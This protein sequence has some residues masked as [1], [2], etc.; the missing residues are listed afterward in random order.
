MPISISICPAWSARHDA[1]R[2]D[3]RGDDHKKSRS[4]PERAGDLFR[5]LSTAIVRCE[6]EPRAN[7]WRRRVWRAG[8]ARPAKGRRSVPPSSAPVHSKREGVSDPTRRRQSWPRGRP[9][10]S[11]TPSASPSP[12]AVV[13]R[14]PV[15]S[16]RFNSCSERASH[17]WPSRPAKR[18]PT[19]VRIMRNIATTACA[20]DAS[21]CVRWTCLFVW[22]G[23]HVFPFW[24]DTRARQAS[25]LRADPLG[26]RA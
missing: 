21:T 12:D 19:C 20:A 7:R 5:R 16:C 11:L 22:A 4:S 13:A 24:S 1:V 18:E 25:G 17:W 10:G 2:R 9:R 8:V 23:H 3:D 14:V 26:L 6:F 15:A